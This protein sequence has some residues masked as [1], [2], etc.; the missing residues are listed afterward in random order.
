MEVEA[1]GAAAAAAAGANDA[2]G[3][4]DGDALV[5]ILHG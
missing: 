1:G 5:G 3:E 4:R 2:G